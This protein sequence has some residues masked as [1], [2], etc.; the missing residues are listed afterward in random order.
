MTVDVNGVSLHCEIVG[1]G[2]P[3]LWLHGFFGAGEDW[4]SIFKAPPGGFRVIAPDLRGHGASTNP[5]KTFSF[6]DAAL[7]V[8]GLLGHLNIERVRAIG[9]SGGGIVLLHMATL[10]PSAISSMVLV[11]APPYFPAQTRARQRQM[12]E[13]AFSDTEMNL[14]RRRHKNGETQIQQLL[15][16][17]RAFADTYDDVS[18]TPPLL[19]TIT[20]DTLIVFG[21]CDPLYP[22]SLAFELHA[23][24]PRSRLWIV[25]NGGHGPVFGEAAAAF[26]QT[27]QAFLRGEWGRRQALT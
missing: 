10:Q 27:A 8:L 7:D 23:A 19:S 17:C 14:M 13:A 12:S 5:S 15:A 24:I 16:Q 4:Q 21:D 6:R 2:E 18:F 1:E 22:V 9:L 26:S 11:S 25:P 20:A 3:L